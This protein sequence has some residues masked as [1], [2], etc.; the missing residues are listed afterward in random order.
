[1]DSAAVT[2]LVSMYHF[3]NKQTFIYHMTKP[4]ESMQSSG[5][6]A[7]FC[8]K[9]LLV[10]SNPPQHSGTAPTPNHHYNCQH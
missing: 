9:E 3:T 4:T 1:M 8:D 7:L 10:A 6:G 2:H 5:K